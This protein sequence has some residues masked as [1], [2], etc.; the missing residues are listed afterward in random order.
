MLYLRNEYKV[1][2]QLLLNY[3]KKKNL[4]GPVISILQVG[5]VRLRG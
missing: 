4:L 5:T 2:S 3:K 1:I